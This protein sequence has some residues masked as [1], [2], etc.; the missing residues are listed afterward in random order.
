MSGYLGEDGPSLDQE[1]WLA[2]RDINPSRTTGPTYPARVP[3]VH[4]KGD[5]DPCPRHPPLGYCTAEDDGYGCTWNAGHDHPQHV[6]GDGHVV[7]H[8]WPVTA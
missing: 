1:E 4:R 3:K 5:V 6:A 2:S 7:V 8:V